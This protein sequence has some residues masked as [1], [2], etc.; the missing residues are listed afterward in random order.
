MLKDKVA[1]VADDPS[2]SAPVYLLDD[3]RLVHL[4]NVGVPSLPRCVP[5]KAPT[6]VPVFLLV[7]VH[8]VAAIVATVLP[9]AGTGATVV[10]VPVGVSVG[11]P[12]PEEAPVYLVHL[13]EE[14]GASREAICVSML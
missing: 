5:L 13:R 7:G 8:V 9:D 3:C 14:T 11:V 1:L 4:V 12:D 10:N 6:L 2:P